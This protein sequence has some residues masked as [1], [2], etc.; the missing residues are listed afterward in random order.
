[1][2]CPIVAVLL[3]AASEIYAQPIGTL[4]PSATPPAAPP[5]PSA[6]P[7][8]VAIELSAG[9]DVPPTARIGIGVDGRILPWLSVNASVANA[10]GDHWSGA[11]YAASARAHRPHVRGR[12]SAGLSLGIAVGKYGYTPVI[13]SH[14]S[15]KLWD[16]AVIA[17]A[18]GSIEWTGRLRVRLFLEAARVL[19]ASSYECV[20]DY[21]CDDSGATLV[22]GGVAFGLGIL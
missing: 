22:G 7:A 20:G 16:R 11:Q 2:L 6:A 5:P 10:G 3:L 4:A 8:R 18:Q 17:R 21:D 9:V 1:V 15:T 14:S 13:A 19:N 12:S